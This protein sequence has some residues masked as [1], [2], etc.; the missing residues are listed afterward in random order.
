VPPF[1]GDAIASDDRSPRIKGQAARPGMACST[2]KR[3]A[4][5]LPSWIGR[6]QARCPLAW[7][8]RGGRSVGLHHSAPSSA[9]GAS[10]I[11]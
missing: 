10:S 8:L 9:G 11:S 2:K 4:L 7:P 6:D 3:R 5:A 1:A